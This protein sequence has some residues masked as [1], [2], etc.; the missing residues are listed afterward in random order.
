LQRWCPEGLD[1]I[2]TELLL[3]QVQI[4]QAILFDSR[5]SIHNVLLPQCI[6]TS[7][8][9]LKVTQCHQCF[10]VEVDNRKIQPLSHSDAFY[11]V[12]ILPHGLHPNLHQHPTKQHH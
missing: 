11:D 1:R 4:P 9:H 10:D 2:Y 6:A 8:G 12:Q 5:I 3:I 7:I